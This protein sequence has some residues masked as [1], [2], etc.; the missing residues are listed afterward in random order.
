MSLETHILL[1]WN[2][3]AHI[4]QLITSFFF[5]FHNFMTRIFFYKSM[6]INFIKTIFWTIR[7]MYIKAYLKISESTPSTF[8]VFLGK[9]RPFVTGLMVSLPKLSARIV[10]WQFLTNLPILTATDRPVRPAPTTHTFVHMLA[11]WYTKRKSQAIT[12]IHRKSPRCKFRE[13]KVKIS[14]FYFKCY[15]IRKITCILFKYTV[16]ESLLI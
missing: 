4:T 9:K 16:I 12:I 10:T 5:T 7:N 8:V 13:N 3:R 6:A 11:L 1:F 14:P 15:L 2:K